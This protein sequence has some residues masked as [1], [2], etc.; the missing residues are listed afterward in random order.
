M[1]YATFV[2]VVADKGWTLADLRSDR[3]PPSGELLELMDR[4]GLDA[5]ERLV[6]RYQREGAVNSA[7]VRGA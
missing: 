2:K 5:Y 1:R 6:L 3:A 4:I 7:R